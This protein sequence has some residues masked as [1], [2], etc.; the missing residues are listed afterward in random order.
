MV[1]KM[2]DERAVGIYTIV[3]ILLL[4]VYVAINFLFFGGVRS[5]S[6]GMELWSWRVTL[7]LA[8]FF[9]VAFGSKYIARWMIGDRW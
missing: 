2:S 4:L 9:G 3:V 8:V 6:A 7:N 1:S 5:D